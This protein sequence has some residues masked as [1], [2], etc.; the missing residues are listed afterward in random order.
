MSDELQKLQAGG[1]QAVAELFSEYREQ[2]E[3]MIGF[4]MDTRLR[5]RLDPADVLQEA[6]LNIANRADEYLAQPRVSD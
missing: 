2:L 3:H 1:P 4:R 6:W 5:G